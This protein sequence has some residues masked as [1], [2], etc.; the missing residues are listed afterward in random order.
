MIILKN[1][2]ISTSSL[3]ITGIIVIFRMNEE[4]V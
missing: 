2:T 3:V 1:G 4:C